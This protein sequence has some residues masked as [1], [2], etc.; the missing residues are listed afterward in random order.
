MKILSIHSGPINELA[1][2]NFPDSISGD[3]WPA[4]IFRMGARQALMLAFQ[5]HPSLPQ[6]TKCPRIQE[7]RIGKDDLSKLASF[8]TR[9]DAL[10]LVYD[11]DNQELITPE[12]P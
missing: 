8:T 12:L 1:L 9:D 5:E 6:H 10:V 11:E 3:G 7:M 2:V 4:Y